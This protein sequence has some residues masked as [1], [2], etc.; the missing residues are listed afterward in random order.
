MANTFDSALVTDVLRDTAI[1]V[2]QSRLA[3]LS[4]FSQDFSADAIAPRRT[5]QVP[6]AT[7]G[8]TTQTNATNFESGDSTLDNVAVTVDQYSNSFALTNAEINQGFRIQNI[9]KINLHQLANKI[10][11][12]AFTPITTTNFGSAVVDVNTAADFTVAEL[13]TL[14]GALKDGDV[15]NVILDGSIYAQFLPSNL[16]AF[17]VASGGKNVGMYGF[18]L[19][20]YNNRWTGAGSNIRGF[21]CSPQAVAVAS[22]LPQNSPASSDMISQENIVIPD[23]GLTV[24]MNMWVSRS[25]RALWASYDVMF[26]AAKGDGSALKIAVLTP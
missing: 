3:P 22:G 13:K 2:L 21:A 8:S 26:G 17:Q 23:L 15:R 19:F 10:I 11:D 12:V 14:W 24:Q 9:A 7:A 25:S 16:E 6:I 5:V 18:D 4:A 20:T 1:T